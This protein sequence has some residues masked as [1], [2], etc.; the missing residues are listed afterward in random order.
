MEEKIWE[1]NMRELS[2][3][4]QKLLSLL[5][6]NSRTSVSGL[7]KAMGVSRITVQNHM[8]M[9]ER[10]KVI[11]GYTIDWHPDFEI[12]QIQAHILIETDQKKIA[13]IVKKLKDIMVIKS[14]SSISGEFDLVAQLKAP[15][16]QDLDRAMDEMSIIDGVM[17][18]QTSVLLSKKFER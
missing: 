17:R 2:Q 4:D 1:G 16:T 12:N 14:L 18:T 9:L 6:A 5:L 7:S 15:S 11:Q 10:N 13:A 3:L 8:T